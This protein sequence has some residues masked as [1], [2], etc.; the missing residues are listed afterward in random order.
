[1][2]DFKLNEHV[3]CKDTCDKWLDAKVVDLK[4]TAQGELQ[5]RISFTGFSSKYDEWVLAGDQ[6]KIL[7]QFTST[8]S[9]DSLLVNNRLDILDLEK[10][11]WREARVTGIGKGSTE[12]ESINIHYKGLSAKFDEKIVRSDFAE[13]IKSVQEGFAARKLK[14]AKKAEPK[15]I[16]ESLNCLNLSDEAKDDDEEKTKEELALEQKIK[17]EQFESDIK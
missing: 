14:G 4:Q 7:K 17:E 9:Y 2:S 5:V 13:R 11:K 16:M 8:S 3:D 6:A 12:I 15:Q 10:N 1:M